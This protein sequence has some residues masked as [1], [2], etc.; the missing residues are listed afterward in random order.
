[1]IT[2]TAVLEEVIA[3]AITRLHRLYGAPAAHDGDVALRPGKR[4]FV[5]E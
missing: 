3:E 5:D 1:M 4:L 2:M